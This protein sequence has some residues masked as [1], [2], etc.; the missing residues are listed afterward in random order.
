M[1][2]GL[3]KLKMPVYENHKIEYN[4]ECDFLPLSQTELSDD[5]R[6]KVPKYKKQ[7]TLHHFSVILTELPFYLW[8]KLKYNNEDNFYYIKDGIYE[9]SVVKTEYDD[10]ILELYNQLYY[11][12]Y[13]N[14]L[15]DKELYE[16]LKQ[17]DYKGWLMLKAKKL[18]FYFI[19]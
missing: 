12:S 3:I 18:I 10:I 2:L 11:K 15:K 6:Q 4:Y 1:E 5:W 13:P 14:L 17:N 16:V 7:K 9:Y 8:K 19:Y